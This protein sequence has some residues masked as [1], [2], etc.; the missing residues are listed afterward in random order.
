MICP[1]IFALWIL[2]S[3]KNHFKNLFVSGILF[4]I[5]ALFKI[6]SAFDILGIIVFWLIY[7]KFNFKELKTFVIKSLVLT[8]GFIFQIALTFIWFYFTGSI[9]EYLVAAFLQ[10]LGYVSSWRASN[11]NI[12]FLVKNAPL[13]IRAGVMFLGFI[14]LWLLKNKLSKQ[15]VFVSSWLLATLF[16]V[17]L[18]ERP[19]PHYFVQSLAPISILIGMLITLQNVEQ[20]LVIFPLALAFFVPFYFKFWYYPT[21]SYYQRF[22]EFTL[23]RISKAEY[24]SRFSPNLNENYKISEFLSKSTNQN[25]NVFVWSND[26]SAIYA[27]SRKLPKTKYVADYHTKDFSSPEEEIKKLELNRP[28]FIVITKNSFDFPELSSFVSENYYIISE[29][30]SSQIWMDMN[31]YK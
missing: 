4:S 11:Q 18:S 8:L 15:F 14:I 10:N 26:S 28:K 21:I 13:L 9:K 7:T 30:G 2:L 1:V 16:A 31:Q 12:P 3:K 24:F 25:G 6:P 20:A 23:G 5:A 17:T 29:T 22:I 27:L 19:Y